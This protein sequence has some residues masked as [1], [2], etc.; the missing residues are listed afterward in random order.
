MKETDSFIK[1][2]HEFRDTVD[3]DSAG[4]VP[5]LDNV[6]WYMMMGVP[7]V[8][9]DDETSDNA[10][11][12]AVEQRVTILKAVFAEVNRKQPG[13]FVEQG[14]KIYDEAGKRVR[15][16]LEDEHHAQPVS[17]HP[18]HRSPAEGIKT[19]EGA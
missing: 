2:Y 19:E 4:I 12:Q 3:L 1:A 5:D 10:T 7:H 17:G 8:P 11:E 18:S 13:E 14:L 9:A 15:K 6:V 16:M